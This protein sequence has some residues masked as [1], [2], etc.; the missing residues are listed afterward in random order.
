MDPWRALGAA[1][2]NSG[3]GCFA[4]RVLPQAKAEIPTPLINPVSL[5]G[6]SAAAPAGAEEPVRPWCR[7][8]VARLSGAVPGAE[9][10]HEP[11]EELFGLS[12][13][14]F[15]IKSTCWRPGVDAHPYCHAGTVGHYTHATLIP[16][17]P[18][19]MR[20]CN[21]RSG[22]RVQAWQGRPS[23]TSS[24][25]RRRGDDSGDLSWFKD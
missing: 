6:G 25:S 2:L 22:K 8:G 14:V 12:V 24:F 4:Q 19:A 15:P 21:P 17:F 11:R 16:T 3:Q 1:R 9:R 20:H 5:L 10:H 13:R 18:A 7:P 23:N